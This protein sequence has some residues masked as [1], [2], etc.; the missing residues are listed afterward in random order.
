MSVC[1]VERPLRH[2]Q[3]LAENSAAIDAISVRG[4]NPRTDPNPAISLTSTI[5]NGLLKSYH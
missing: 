4:S 2:F 5:K 1:T 3:V